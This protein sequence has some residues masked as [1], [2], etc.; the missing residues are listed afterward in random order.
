MNKKTIGVY[1]CDEIPPS[2]YLIVSD[3]LMSLL[4]FLGLFFS[5]CQSLCTCFVT[6]N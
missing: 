6:S 2:V 1:N 5:L 4:S 3:V